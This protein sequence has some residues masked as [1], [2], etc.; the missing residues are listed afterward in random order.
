MDFLWHEVSEDE[1]EEIR[2][3]ARGIMDNFSK[4]LSKIDSKKLKEPLIERLECERE[5][6]E[7]ALLSAPQS[8]ELRGNEIDRG[9]MFENASF[10][11]NDFIIA[12]KKTW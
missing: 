11:N 7:M 9:I 8:A 12:E 1:R 4:K 5:E 3:Q 2:K 6:G 10:K